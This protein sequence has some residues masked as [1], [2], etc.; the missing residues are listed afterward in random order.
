MRARS[1][2]LLGSLL[3]GL[4]V[5]PGS[6]PRSR[7]ESG[8]PATIPVG[9]SPSP[10]QL[11][12]L[13]VSAWHSAGFKGQGVK[14]AIL[15]S[16]F[17]HYHDFLQTI[18]PTRVAVHSARRD[19]DLEAKD[20]QHGI[21]CGEV[22]HRLAPDAQ[23][24]FA[25]WEPDRP[26]QFLDAVRWARSQGAQIL[27]CSLIMPS[28]SDG[29]GGGPT[30]TALADLLG[31]S[32]PQALF[33]ACAGNTAQRHWYGEFRPG[34]AGWHDWKPDA[35]LNPVTPW[36]DDEVSVELY[37]PGLADFDLLVKDLTQSAIM[38]QS[39]A[40]S[41]GRR[42]CA[43]ARFL[44]RAG[45]EYAVLVRQVWGSRGPFHLAALG[46]NLGITTRSG[47]VAFPADG[48]EVV[49]V[50]AVDE[51]GQ[52]MPYSACGPSSAVLKPDLMAP[53]PW[54]VSGRSR[55]FSGTSAAAPQA[56]AL[57]ALWWS[58]Y[59][60]WSAARIRQALRESALDLGAPGPDCEMGYGLIH[61]PP[62]N[63]LI[64]SANP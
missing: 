60:H 14:I 37:W 51:E 55:P 34:R 43:I 62:P 56:A 28:W 53:V 63:P 20:S 11:T 46:G 42:H 7:A 29:A 21:L 4:L 58:R 50:G 30:H 17:R 3:V 9:S 39:I 41:T 5:L 10:A 19:G 36:S 1:A 38:A 27:S 59:P 40:E 31:T 25:N 57:A 64:P 2:G 24:L 49:A 18:L 35:T 48:K 6:P 16:G 45:H 54:R 32:S 26:D 13:G 52:R 47:S 12:Q 23:L 8:P 33:V 22:I 44:P 15:D 61:L